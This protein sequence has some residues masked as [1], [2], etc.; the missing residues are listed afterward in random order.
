MIT[1]DPLTT[2]S[3]GSQL[4]VSTQYAGEGRFS[5]ELY[6]SV[7]RGRDKLDLRAVSDRLEGATCGEAQDIAYSYATRLYPNTPSGMKKP[8]Y[9]IWPGPNIP[10]APESRGRRG[11]RR[12]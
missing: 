7:R 12:T 8:P 2:F 11:K 6:Q 10:I 3:D 1:L 5:C 9:L 4:V